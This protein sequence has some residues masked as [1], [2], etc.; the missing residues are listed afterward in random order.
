MKYKKVT[1]PVN[2]VLKS[3]VTYPEAS[4]AMPPDTLGRPVVFETLEFDGDELSPGP[5]R[6]ANR[7][8]ITSAIWRECQPSRFGNSE[9]SPEQVLD[10]LGKHGINPDQLVLKSVIQ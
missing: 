6:F 8:E 5:S 4:I 10:W 7:H 1:I 2:F 3:Q 9:P